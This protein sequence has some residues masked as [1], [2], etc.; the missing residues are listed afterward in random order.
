MTRGA[1]AAQA[2]TDDG[3]SFQVELPAQV[4]AD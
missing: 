1:L 3:D 2:T 4:T